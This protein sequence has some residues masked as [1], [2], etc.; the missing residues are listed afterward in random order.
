MFCT[1]CGTELPENANFCPKCGVRTAKGVEAKA[2]L[3]YRDI[4]DNVEN[5]LEKALA[6]A[7]EEIRD[8]FNKAFGRNQESS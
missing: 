6:K 8:A 7:S 5:Q 1:N 4:M 2:P 3:P